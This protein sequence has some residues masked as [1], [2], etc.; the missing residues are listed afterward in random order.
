MG[1]DEPPGPDTRMLLATILEEQQAC[2]EDGRRPMVEDYLA[3]YPALQDDAEGLLDL[4]YQEFVIRRARGETPCPEEYLR[5]FP[6]RTDGLIRQFAVD[7]ALRSVGEGTVHLP[8]DE[9]STLAGPD[10][11]PE[12]MIPPVPP[13]SIDGYEILGELGRGGMGVVYRALDRRLNRI[14]A[15]KTIAEAAFATPAQ[16]RR[17]LAEAEVIARLRHAHIIPIYTIGEHLGRPYFSLELA[18]GG[19]LAQRLAKG[20][21]TSRQAGALVETLA[22]AVQAAHAAGII[23]RDLKPSN[24]LLAADETPKIADFGLAKLLDDDSARTLSGEVLGTPSY[25]APEQA[26]GRSRDAGPA[27]D[28]YAL[29]TILYQA[30]TGRP[31]FLGASAMETMRLVVT[32]EVVPPRRQRP[33]VPRDLETIALKCL[34]K[35]PRRRYPTAQALADDLRRF[36]DGRSIA[37][38]PVGLTGRL[39]RWCRRNPPLAATAAALVLT[40][41]LGSP[42][43]LGLWLRARA[44][45]GRAEVERDRAERS[46]DRAFSAVSVLLRTEDENI[47]AEELKPYRKAM[48]DAGIRESMALI[49]ELEGD[50]RADYQRIDAYMA[51]ARVQ[52]EAGEGAAAT[53]STRKAIALAESLVARDPSGIRPRVALAA[54]LHRASAFLP[55]ETARREAARRSSEIQRSIPKEDHEAGV[56]NSAA[57]TAMND[58]NSGHEHWMKGRSSEA[59]ADFL[60]ARAVYDDLLDRGERSPQ[61]R[62]FAGRNLLYLCRAYPADRQEE[63]FAAGRRAESIFRTL[64]RDYPD[65]FEFAWQLSLVQDEL[66]VRSLGADRGPEAIQHFEAALGT[67]KDMR[68]H[69]GNL[70]SRMARIQGQIAV[71]GFN[72]LDAYASDP[73]KY[74]SENRA[75]TAEVYEICN[76]LGIVQPLSPNQQVAHAMTSFA[77]ADSRAEDGRG[78]D[79]DLILESDRLWERLLR[80]DPKDSYAKAFLVVVRRRLDEEL[81]DRGQV[82]EAA[83]WGRRALDTARDNP[84]LCYL[85]AIDYARNAGL[86]GKIPNK[87]SAQQ[88]QER[89][90]RFVAGAVAMLRQ[91]VADGFK[92]VARLRG[93][94]T[95]DSIRSDPDFRAILADLEFPADP[96]ASR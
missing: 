64:V 24:V 44:D 17:F 3:R 59:L 1:S 50:P 23:H 68:G 36:L 54:S 88:L 13:G 62:D 51:L 46:R 67:L 77:L 81:A 29:G 35:E 79:L 83:R 12:G 32:T 9:A 91:A 72:L 19:S 85:L 92:D 52:H 37:A 65:R 87:L 6:A 34:E 66:G 89:R 47:L 56:G 4:I 74:A 11:A 55:D 61:T 31:P 10:S 76:K 80:D 60:A 86:T 69:H 84:E 16:V 25:M 94:S 53:E 90:R 70:V 41:A 57:I 82:E 48:V 28:I 49:R 21:M 26:E 63:A 30:L 33:D 7:E 96:F 71:L 22:L 5:R 45:R 2:W 75:L 18:E 43:L 95:F 27:A 39:W 15:I 73:V 14:V 40:F 78:S 58:Y 8:D 20:P 38:R 93:E 42:A